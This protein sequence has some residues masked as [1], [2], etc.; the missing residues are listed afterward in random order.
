[1]KS[2]IAI[3]FILSTTLFISS[4]CQFKDTPF[5][6]WQS[7]LGTID[8][9]YKASTITD[10]QYNVY[11]VGSSI[12][13]FGNY[14]V[15]LVKYDK[16][17]NVLWSNTID[18]NASGDDIGTDV[19]LDNNGDVLITGGV[20]NGTADNYDLLLRK[21]SPA[22]S[23]I[24]TVNYDG[25]AS[26]YD[27][28]A[29]LSVDSNNNIYVAGGS[30]TTSG[31]IDMAVAKYNASGSQQW[32]TH[33]DN[34]NLWDAALK[35]EYK[36][37][38]V[39]ATG[40]SQT[41]LTSWVMATIRL[42]PSTGVI[43][44]TRTSNGDSSSIDEV[45]DLFIDDNGYSYVVGAI[46][47]QS[48]EMNMKVFKLDDDLEIVWEKEYDG[49]S[50]LDDFAESVAV[51]ASD[52]VYVAGYV[53]TSQ[54]KD[55]CTIKYNSSGTQLWVQ[56]WDGSQSGDDFATSLVLN[57]SD[58]PIVGGS[59]F[60]DENMDY[61][62]LKYDVNGS[63]EWSIDY[64]GRANG[65][66]E[67]KDL[68][69]DND[70]NVIVVG[71]SEDFQSTRYVTVKYEIHEVV[72][73]SSEPDPVDFASFR[74]NRGQLRN[75]D[76]LEAS[77]V[78]YWNQGSFPAVFASDDKASLVL[79]VIH[80][81][82]DDTLFRVD[83]NWNKN[84]SAIQTFAL[85]KKDAFENYYNELVPE[86]RPKVPLFEG[87][88]S[89]EV[90]DYVDIVQ[91]HDEDGYCW[92]IVCKPGFTPNAPEFEFSGQDGL[93]IAGDG[94]LII[95]TSLGNMRF[96]A[97]LAFELDSQGTRTEL[98]WSP[99]MV[100]NGAVV[101]FQLGSFNSQNTLVLQF[102]QNAS[103]GGCVEGYYTVGNLNWAT[104]F[105][106]DSNIGWDEGYGV[107][108]DP[109]GGVY[110]C[111]Y[112]ESLDFP[113]QGNE[114][115]DDQYQNTEGTISRFKDI[116]VLDW[117]TFWGGSNKDVV[118]SVLYH[119]DQGGGLV[120]GGHTESSNI[121]FGPVL[122]SEDSFPWLAGQQ[123]FIS[124]FNDING[125]IG[126]GTYC[127]AGGSEN[128]CRDIIRLGNGRIFLIGMTES[129]L[130]LPTL[131]PQN[132]DYYLD[133]YPGGDVSGF[134]FSFNS[135]NQ[136][137]WTTYLG[138][139]ASNIIYE[140]TTVPIGGDIIIGT[141]IDMSGFE[142]GDYPSAYLGSGA[143]FWR[144][145]QDGD[146]LWRAGIPLVG[147]HSVHTHVAFN[148]DQKLFIAGVTSVE[149][150]ES[151]TLTCTS[152][153]T[154]LIPICDPGNNA[155]V[156]SNDPREGVWI[157][158]FDLDDCALLWSTFLGSDGY[159]SHEYLVS[160]HYNE[161][162]LLNLY[163]WIDVT[164]DVNG[165][166]FV[167]GLTTP[168][169]E[170]EGTFNTLVYPGYYTQDYYVELSGQFD[171]FIVGF[172]ENRERYWAT[173]FGGGINNTDPFWE[174]SGS[175][176]IR[177]IHVRDDK[178]FTYGTAHY[179]C[180]PFECP[181]IPVDSWCQDL[182]G[183][184]INRTHIIGEFVLD[185]EI[186]L[187]S[188][189]E[190]DLP[191]DFEIYPNPSSGKFTL[192]SSGNDQIA[193]RVFDSRGRLVFQRGAVSTPYNFVLDVEPGAYMVKLGSG[194]VETTKKIVVLR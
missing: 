127:S 188:G 39:T 15:L 80:Q 87:L 84:N 9:Y 49:G 65:E 3:L 57:E 38:V 81:S 63:L 154:G 123:T 111:G 145:D 20:E 117:S 147:I 120:V 35:V 88:Y 93:S 152:A 137:T 96:E 24:W 66:D 69:L 102:K 168:W 161:W 136:Q 182:E 79:G 82:A 1:M 144:F 171:P 103:S 99:T 183:G 178:L 46:D 42:N 44:A 128:T 115:I 105:S 170:P 8:F 14:D 143:S 165:R 159:E 133:S 104:H 95:T 166:L 52:N 51:D 135:Q 60:H 83:V 167:T 94:A 118:T 157:A 92:Y 100:I 23:I 150:S 64:N 181:T 4:P 194:D 132:G 116:S 156:T 5:E 47:S 41:S 26:S 45:R 43:T 7:G 28:G 54:G 30:S 163:R 139:N 129:G 2:K 192:T 106:A 131:N 91:T 27:G 125:E 62:I 177:E 174:D 50:S 179:V 101:D 172:T 86:G 78:K 11:V 21:F 12:N 146:L 32:I 36:N 53:S 189:D 191:Q 148:G 72:D 34:T 149:E 114:S 126:W 175:E 153:G 68:T 151:T 98:M 48:Q 71:S 173:L 90:W 108:T 61:Q 17:G 97:D 31:L 10:S 74:E 29:S 119:S 6:S 186:V 18:G 184:P 76:G 193:I 70:G 164:T 176:W 109:N 33:W 122:P 112:T 58:E 22:G 140:G 55:F 169:Q 134:I 59:T 138:N 185:E 180:Q 85:H 37:G 142:N 75:S 19:I 16:F 121:P 13:A 77:E 107:T 141:N 56:T 110:T 158:E 73:L 155:Y 187:D 89:P 113:T 130:A 162:S 25:P 160:E 40:G 124:R 67:L 190:L